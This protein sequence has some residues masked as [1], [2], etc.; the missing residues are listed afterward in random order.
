MKEEFLK[1]INGI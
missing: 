1:T